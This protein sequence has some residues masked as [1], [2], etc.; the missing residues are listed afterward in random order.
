MAQVD[1]CE[2]DRGSKFLDLGLAYE[3]AVNG[4]GVAL[5]RPSLMGDWLERKALQPLFDVFAEPTGSYYLLPGNERSRTE[6]FTGWLQALCSRLAERNLLITRS[7]FA[8]TK[9]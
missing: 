1:C 3:A 6:S 8:G 9:P 2:S 7:Y 5:C 4:Q